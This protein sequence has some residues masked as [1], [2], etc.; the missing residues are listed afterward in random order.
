M[1]GLAQLS[2]GLDYYVARWYDPV[3]GRFVQLD[4]IISHKGTIRSYD[5]YSY[6]EN[7]PINYTDPSGN[8]YCDSDGHCGSANYLIQ[9]NNTLDTLQE[10]EVNGTFQTQAAQ[11][12]A[13]EAITI[14][15]NKLKELTGLQG[16]PG[17]VFKAYHGKT[18]INILGDDMPSSGNCSVN[19]QS[20]SCHQI[21]TM[22]NYLHEF[23]HVFENHM[24]YLYG[25][26]ASDLD[27]IQVKDQPLM[28]FDDKT[29]SWVRQTIGFI[30]ADK[31]SLEH[32]PD[33][34]YI[35]GQE[36]GKDIIT[37][38]QHNGYAKQEQWADTYLNYLL[39]GSGDKNHGFN[40]DNYG[41]ARR[42]AFQQQ[43]TWIIN[44]K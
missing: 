33:M 38:D 22:A 7:N 36:N 28:D 44:G 42:K 39:D 23:G 13:A 30:Y 31:R 12:N 27:P 35:I 41:D 43:I 1:R 16:S 8:M 24:Y 9:I 3:L 37:Y 17:F 2:I 4:N 6:V 21:P 11:N 10:A 20:I 25:R 34:G 19:D 18:T 5:R 14:T 15:G 26:K 29:N 32:Y 40:N